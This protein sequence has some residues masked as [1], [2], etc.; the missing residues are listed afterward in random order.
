VLEMYFKV[1]DIFKGKHHVPNS[2]MPLA[3]TA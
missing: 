1:V 2:A 3:A